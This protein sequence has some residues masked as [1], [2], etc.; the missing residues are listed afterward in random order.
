MKVRRVLLG[1]E[2]YPDQT[3]ETLTRTWFS[4]Y[5]VIIIGDKRNEITLPFP[6][7]YAPTTNNGVIVMRARGISMPQY[8][9][10]TLA[11]RFFFCFRRRY[12]CFSSRAQQCP[13][14]SRVCVGPLY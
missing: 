10:N 13:P 6:R 4:K 5:R 9:Y 3:R 1:I 12:C 2:T 8:E 7:P 11:V 14:T